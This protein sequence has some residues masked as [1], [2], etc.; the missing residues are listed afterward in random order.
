MTV[1]GTH[2]SRL[3]SRFYGYKCLKQSPWKQKTCHLSNG[4]I[5]VQ[6]EVKE[7]LDSGKP[8]VALESTIITHGMPYPHNL[9]T[10]Q[11]VENLVRDQGVIPAT[12]AVING[13]VKVGLTTEELELLSKKDKPCLKASRRDLSYI[14]SQGINGGTTVS[15][16]M[17]IANQVGIPI[18]VTGGIGGVHRGAETSM[19][20]SADLT[21]LGRTPVT[22]I[23]AGVKSILDIGRTLEYLETKGVCVASYGNSKDFPAFFVPRSG[24]QSP[25]NVQDATKAAELIDAQLRLGLQ[26]GILIAVPIPQESSADG[27]IIEFAIQQALT[28]AKNQNI[29][30]KEVTPFVLQ[31]VNEMTQ[32]S[33]LTANIALVKNNAI[34]GSQIAMKLCDIRKKKVGVISTSRHRYPSNQKTGDNRIVVIGGSIVDFYAKISSQNI[35]MDGATY[36]GNV[37]QSFGG[38]GRNLADCLSR[39]ETNPLFISA[40]GNDANRTVFEDY[41]KHMDLSGV[42]SL[43]KFNTATYCAVLSS[44]G[45]LMFGIGDMDVHKQIT[46][47][48]ISR[49]EKNLAL[50]SMVV[51]DGNISTDS[52]EYVCQIC[53][54]NHVPVWY[55]PTDVNK[56]HKPFLTSAGQRLTYISPNLNELRVIYRHLTNT[57]ESQIGHRDPDVITLEGILD[58]AIW[59]SKV[60]IEEVPIVLVTLGKHGVMLCQRSQIQKFPVK[61]YRL[62]HSDKMTADIFPAFNAGYPPENIVSVSGAGDC[63]AAT[64]ISGIVHG[65]DP[66]LCV[67]AGLMAAQMSLKSYQAVPP[68]I[69]P[70]KLNLDRVRIWAPWQPQRVKHV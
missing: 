34:V 17:S 67:K 37:R 13:K 9:S 31:K 43:D 53:H 1:T 60:I 41:C 46:P 15:G 4:V 44:N 14:I 48:Y 63:L 28:E 20:I 10:A 47:D 36:P 33:S 35:Q 65:H 50:A 30:G 29:I 38:V 2:F 51:L 45:E 16:T 11:S 42:T 3:L 21:E 23:S 68:N 40:T 58:E 27:E 54:K 49:Y 12:I 59:L 66:D 22:V 6:D 24:Y 70:K 61:G 55:E 25:Y 39:L 18:F 32:G 62:E 57:L 64:M 19:D 26:S 7:A 56:A 69:S 8:V 52:I 5:E